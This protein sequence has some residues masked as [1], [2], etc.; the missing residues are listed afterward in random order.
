MPSGLRLSV[1]ALFLVAC[2]PQQAELD[3]INRKLDE[4]SAQQQQLLANLDTQ[5]A[6]ERQN[7]RGGS[8]QDQEAGLSPAL[9]DR[10]DDIEGRL[11]LL[12]EDIRQIRRDT[13]DGARKKP[14]VRPGRPDP[15]KR[16]RVDV[17]KSHVAGRKD[18]LVTI[19][20][21]TDYQCPF[22]KR[23]QPTLE[24]LRSHYG[25][26]IRIVHKHN[27]LP[28]HPR[29]EP[30]AMAAEAAGRQGKFWQMHDKLY[31]DTRA[32]TDENIERYAKELG[33]D[34]RKFKRDRSDSALRDRIKAEQLQGTSVG[35]RG[36]PAFFINGRFLSGA[37]PFE[38][39]ENLIDEERSAAKKMVKQGTKRSKIYSTLMKTA[40]TGV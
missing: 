14:S 11:A 34:M 2:R 38:S 37:Q 10:F 27:P 21:F 32:L 29:A 31:Q 9:D 6:Q 28:M 20:A 19:I 4:V 16:Y 30:A 13:N 26:D 3:E 24:K 22:C 15:A 8:A 7:A 39:F 40:E 35:A 18:A 17:G 25:R 12:S 5:W 1:C 36:T 33:L 23:V